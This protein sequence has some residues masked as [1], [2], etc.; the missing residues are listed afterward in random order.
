MRKFSSSPMKKFYL[1]PLIVVL[2]SVL[3]LGWFL[4]VVKAPSQNTNFKNF[5]IESGESATQIGTALENGGFV[6]SALAFKIYAQ[7]TGSAG[8]IQAGEYRLTPSYTLFQVVSEL[9][10]GPIEVWVTIPEGLRREEIASKFTKALDQDVTFEN[11]FLAASVG[12]EGFLFPDTYL[13][14]KEASASAIVNKMVRNF[15]AK[16]SNLGSGK[17][18]T[19]DQRIVLASLIERETRAEEERSVVAGILINRLSVGMPLQ[20]DATVQYAVASENC[21]LKIVNCLW[22]QPLNSPDLSINSPYNTYLNQGLPPAPIAN[23]GLSSI[24]AA[25]NPAQTDYYYYIH[26][27]NGQIHYAR[28]LDEQNANIAKYLH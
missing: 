20:V 4:Q 7:F 26:D 10:R 17:D 28:T 27:A 25:F 12:Q 1:L 16:T 6:K 5:A 21:K 18:L 23:P 11:Q 2:L 22:W 15:G 8:R 3:V 24:Q 13:F 19:F 9:T 14:S